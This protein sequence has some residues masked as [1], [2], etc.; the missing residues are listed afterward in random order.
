MPR[1][2][3]MDLGIGKIDINLGSFMSQKDPF[4]INMPKRRKGENS[5]AYDMGRAV[6]TARRTTRKVQSKFSGHKYQVLTISGGVVRKHAF[7]D[8]R[9]AM[10]FREASRASG[11]YE[12]VSEITEMR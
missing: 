5:L 3:N 8:R 9:Q 2:N 12:N 7:R 1:K 10:A 4:R 11:S 6:G